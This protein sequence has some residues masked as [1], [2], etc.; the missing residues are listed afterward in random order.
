MDS[1][2]D[3]VASKGCLSNAQ[4]L[5]GRDASIEIAIRRLMAGQGVKCEEAQTSG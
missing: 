4:G 3:H 1:V 5:D 2:V